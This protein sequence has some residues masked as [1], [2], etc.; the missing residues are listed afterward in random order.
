MWGLEVFISDI[1]NFKRINQELAIIRSKF[2]DGKALNGNSKKKKVCR[3]LFIFLL[4]HDIDL[5]HMEAMDLRSFSK[6]TEK[7]MGYLFTSLLVNSNSDLIWF[8]TIAI[9]NDLT[10]HNPIFP[11]HPGGWGQ[12]R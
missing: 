4:G 7:Q 8:V 2:K 10:S 1:W 3:L 12:H 6:Y 11:L 5:G 9:K